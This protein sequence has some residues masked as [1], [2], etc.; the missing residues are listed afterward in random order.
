MNT[1]KI[2]KTI[3]RSQDLNAQISNDKMYAILL[4]LPISMLII[5]F[6]C[7]RPLEIIKGLDAIRLA[8][9]VLLTDYLL[10]GGMGSS[11]ANSAMLML[12]NIYL[13][14]K[15]KLR[16]NGIIISTLFLIGGF[17]FMGKNI[18]NVGPFYLGGF[19]YSRYHKI[20][21]KNVIIISMLST[22]LSPIS[23]V[24]ADSVQ[25]HVLLSVTLAILVSSF[26]GFIMPTISSHVL[27]AHAGYSL[28]NMGFAAGLVGMVVYALLDA[29]GYEVE[30]NSKLYTGDTTGVMIYLILFSCMLIGIG[31]WMND[32]SFKGLK[33]V[34]KH[35]GRLVTDMIKHVGFPLSLINM[36]LLGLVAILYVVVLRGEFNGPVI[37]GVLTVIGFGAFG[38]HLK[39]SV[40]ILVGVLISSLVIQKD[41]DISI[42]IIAGLFG[43][44]L[45]PI[46]GEYGS[47]YGLVLGFLHLAVTLNIGGTH[48][49]LHLYNNGL[50]AGIIATLFIPMLDAFKREK[51]HET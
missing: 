17:G 43:T 26:I 49:G 40:P 39:N 13:L 1:I 9:D 38:K 32:R 50:S 8:N 47:I 42:I 7:D 3:K 51:N 45:A 44:T 33:E 6:L 24:L 35:P 20:P 46:V 37:A 36:G 22:T 5:A 34:F 19:L 2:T 11:L 30:Q 21:Y 4:I 48:G 31:Y 12:F 16:P 10:V 25:N 15:L 18:F 41:V 23:S 28:Y 27:T 14:R 29:F